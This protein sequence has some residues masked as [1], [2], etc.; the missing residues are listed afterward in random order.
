MTDGDQVVVQPVVYDLIP[1][2]FPDDEPSDP[3]Y[4][5]C[6]VYL[7]IGSGSREYENFHCF[8]CSPRWLVDQFSEA[9]VVEGNGAL[10]DRSSDGSIMFGSGLVLM[11]SW[12]LPTLRRAI[13]DFL[14]ECTGPSWSVVANKIG[15][16]FPWEFDHWYDEYVEKHPEKFDWPGKLHE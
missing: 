10:L 1:L 8:S 4:F 5:G 14:V 16:R 13:D 12:S 11:H 3:T 7:Y 15:R 2:W 6:L 9:G